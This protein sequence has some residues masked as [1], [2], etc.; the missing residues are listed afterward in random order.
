LDSY[1]SRVWKRFLK[2]A[3]PWARDNILWGAVVVVLPPVFVFLRDRHAQIDWTVIRATLVLYSFALPLYFAVH[4]IRTPKKL[5]QERNAREA[6]MRQEIAARD[7]TIKQKN[8]ELEKPKY[9]AAEQ[10]DYE[11]AR[12]ALKTLGQKG[13]IA[14]RHIRR[15]DSLTFGTYPPVLPPGLNSNHTLWVFNHCAS[16]GVLTCN[17][18]HERTYAVAP[19]ME[20]ILD[21]LLYSE[22]VTA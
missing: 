22:D 10:H 17:G 8:A 11:T 1:Y 21:D 5:D 7:E 13:L 3:T 2:D 15:H 9:T 4:L 6:N 20:K 14:L 16:E 12:K 18:T 19:K